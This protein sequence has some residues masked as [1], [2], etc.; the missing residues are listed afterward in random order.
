MNPINNTPINDSTNV[1]PKEKEDE[2]YCDFDGRQVKIYCFLCK[3]WQTLTQ[4]AFSA[5]PEDA[6]NFYNFCCE[7][8]CMRDACNEEFEKKEKEIKYVMYPEKF[9]E[10]RPDID[11]RQAEIYCQQ[12]ATW[13]PLNL[14]NYRT[15]PFGC[16]NH[17]RRRYEYPNGRCCRPE[18]EEIENE[19]KYW[20]QFDDRFYAQE[21]Y[22]QSR[23]DAAEAKCDAIWHEHIKQEQQAAAEKEKKRRDKIDEE[24]K[25]NFEF[26]I[27]QGAAM[28]D[29]GLNATWNEHLARAIEKLEK[30]NM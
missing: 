9:M 6:I 4:K 15:L 17:S 5:L 24:E 30:E 23:C 26:R 3:S 16:D 22:L 27:A 13:Q 19:K 29:A 18:C 2:K 20:K 25:A 10:Q 14:E 11:A 21:S 28:R 7:G 1:E 8:R 12:C